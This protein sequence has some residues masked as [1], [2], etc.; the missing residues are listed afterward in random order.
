M[1]G[2]ENRTAAMNGLQMRL[3]LVTAGLL[4][5][6]VGILSA[7]LVSGQPRL[8]PLLVPLLVLL[9]LA[10]SA[11][12]NLRSFAFTAWVLG[13]VAASMV[14]PKAFGHWLGYDLS[15][16]IVPLVQVI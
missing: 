3:R 1:P 8:G 15:A 11:Q 5:V 2:S 6:V 9:A 13:F 10:F 16:L 12:P 7:M 14:W 4:V